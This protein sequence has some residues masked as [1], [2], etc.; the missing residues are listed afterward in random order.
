MKGIINERVCGMKMIHLER[1]KMTIAL[2]KIFERLGQEKVFIFRDLWFI[3]YKRQ[4]H[5][6]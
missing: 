1:K 5:E 2:K 6:N 3:L 4:N